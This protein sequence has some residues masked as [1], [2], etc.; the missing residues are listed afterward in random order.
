METF[1]ELGLVGLP[2]L[3]GCALVPL[4]AG[5]PRAGDRASSPPPRGAYLAWLAASALDWH[6]EMV[7]LTTTALLAGSACLV[8][9]ERRTRGRASR[10]SRLALVG[11]TGTLSVFA[12]WSLVGNQALSQVVTPSSARTG[13]KR[14]TTRAVRRR[15]SFWSH[16]PDLV[17]GD[18]AAG[19][20]DREGA[21][22]LYRDAVEKDP[23]NWVAW[24]RLAQVER[25]AE[26]AAAYDRV[27]ELNPLEEDLPGE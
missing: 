20:G 13:S 16:E 19:L 9:A 25:G 10:G 5:D 24:L 4:V 14:A 2:L 26:R 15:S 12:V 3:A 1:A 17:L 21:L 6:W 23:R 22:V 27:H 11:L 8:A 18:A 7:G